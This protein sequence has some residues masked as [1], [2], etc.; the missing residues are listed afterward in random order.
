MEYN[1]KKIT[2]QK[3]LH[4]PAKGRVVC[5]IVSYFEEGKERKPKNL[6]KIKSEIG[7]G[8]MRCIKGVVLSA[9]TDGLKKI[10]FIPFKHELNH[11]LKKKSNNAYSPQAK[12][13]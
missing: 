7:Q 2:W 11:I 6:C 13:V 5:D 3:K 10:D 1:Y 9:L 4:R 12:V 8:N